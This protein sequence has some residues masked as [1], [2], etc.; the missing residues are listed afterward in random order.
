VNAI[1]QL[2]GRHAQIQSEEAIVQQQI[3]EIQRWH[4]TRLENADLQAF[5]ERL[6]ALRREESEVKNQLN[7]LQKAQR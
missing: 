3:H 4:R 7:Q 6:T 2:Q 5:Q 1:H